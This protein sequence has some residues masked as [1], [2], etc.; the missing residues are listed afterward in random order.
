LKDNGKFEYGEVFYKL[1]YSHFS[2]NYL[3]FA[4]IV[5]E[6]L[7]KGEFRK[8]DKEFSYSLEQEDKSGETEEK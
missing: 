3:P 4:R 1:S 8:L 5:E 2:G 6:V 7:G